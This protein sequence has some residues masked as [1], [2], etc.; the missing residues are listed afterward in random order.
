MV[1]ILV[2]AGIALCAILGS[3][4]ANADSCDSVLS[5]GTMSKTSVETNDYARTLFV[6]KLAKS[7]YSEAKNNVSL[8]AMLPIEG[9]PVKLGFS[10]NDWHKFQE[11]VRSSIDIDQTLSHAGSFVQLTGDPAITNAWLACKQHSGGLTADIAPR[12]TTEAVVTLKW[13]PDGSTNI[14]P[15]MVSVV[16]RG[17][18]TASE[19]RPQTRMGYDIGIARP[20][21]IVVDRR[22]GGGVLFVANTTFGS[23][24]AYLPKIYPASPPPVITSVNIGQCLGRNGLEGVGFWGPPDNSCNGLSYW[25]S[26][27]LAPRSVTT[28]ASCK[29]HNSVEGVTLWGPAGAACANI[30]YWG[31]YEGEVAIPNGIGSC[32]GRGDVL[33]GH[34]L[35][36][37][38]GLSCGGFPVWGKYE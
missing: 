34:R 33:G 7:T 11:L 29:G 17:G 14:S 30:P 23:A 15:K 31:N 3:S 4:P 32:V 5:S 10:E 16:V 21:T 35:Y 24:E 18:R 1:R 2:L 20:Q 28:L 38:K 26:Y 36:G 22:A 13:L 8:S 9:V 6:A 19:S 25:G 37:P 27:S 12:G